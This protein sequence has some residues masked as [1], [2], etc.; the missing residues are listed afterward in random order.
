LE[1]V[2]TTLTHSP[3]ATAPPATLE[4][5]ILHYTDLCGA[6]VYR[7]ERDE[8]LILRRCGS[9]YSPKWILLAKVRPPLRRIPAS[10][11]AKSA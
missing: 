5:V 10:E 1:V 9:P 7:F 2:N 3:S 11:S 4:R 6:D 8:P